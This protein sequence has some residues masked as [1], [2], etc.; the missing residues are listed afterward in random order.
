MNKGWRSR[1]CLKKTFD[2][3]K[4]WEQ[5]LINTSK[6]TVKS[7]SLW[8]KATYFSTVVYVKILPSQLWADFSNLI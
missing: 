4:A 7:C 5:L 6:M 1:Q 2:F 3:Q 8:E